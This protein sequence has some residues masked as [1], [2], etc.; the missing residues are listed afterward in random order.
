MLVFSC[1][2][3]FLLLAVHPFADEKLYA[4]H[5]FRNTVN[6]SAVCAVCY[7][8]ALAVFPH[9][10]IRRISLALMLHTAFLLQLIPKRLRQLKLLRLF[11][12]EFSLAFQINAVSKAFHHVVGRAVMNFKRPHPY[13]VRCILCQFNIF[14][15]KGQ[16]RRNQGQPLDNPL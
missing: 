11:Y 16:L 8:N 10:H 4:L 12:I 15:G 7:G 1:L 2:L 5:E 6:R 14:D 9:Y 13:R 3:L